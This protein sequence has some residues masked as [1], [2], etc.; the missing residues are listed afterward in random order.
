MIKLRMLENIRSKEISQ[1][2]VVIGSK[3]SMWGYPEQYKM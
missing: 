3:Q 2:A 1:I